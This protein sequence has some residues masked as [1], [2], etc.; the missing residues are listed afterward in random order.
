MRILYMLFYRSLRVNHWML[1]G[2]AVLFVVGSGWFVH[3]LEPEK[4]DHPFTGVWYVMTTVTTV[5]YGDYAPATTI[6]RMFGMFLFIFGVALIGLLIGKVVDGFGVL[7]RR[8]EEGRLA[9]HGQQH[10]LMVGFSTKTQMAIDELLHSPQHISIV[11]IDTLAKTPID[12]AQVHY[13]QGDPTSE[14]TLRQANLHA[15]R[16]VIIFADDRIADTS[17]IDGKSLLIVSTI[18]RIAPHVYTTVEIMLEKHIAN[19]AHVQVNDFILSQETISRLAVRSALSVTMNHIF[20]QLL[21]HRDGEDLFELRPDPR[22]KT[23]GEA[24]TALLQQGATL[25]A[26]RDNLGINRMLHHDIPSDAVLCVICNDTTFQRIR[27][28]TK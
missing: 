25:I 1:F 22:W 19:F 7:K 4:F 24:F 3:W 8:K 17:L 15:A 2:F 16:S 13:I 18:E 11:V 23:Y 26:D 10:V 6:G 28:A 21:T 5:G 9:Y 14:E 20:N 27:A 12:H